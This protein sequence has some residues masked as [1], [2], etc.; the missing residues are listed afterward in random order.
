MYV[1]LTSAR[2]INEHTW[3]WSRQIDDSSLRGRRQ[4]G[5]FCGSRNGVMEWPRTRLCNSYLPVHVQ[6]SVHTLN[7]DS[8]IMEL[9][10]FPTMHPCIFY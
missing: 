8:Q 9:W 2:A 10:I 6:E 4:A 1:V 3:R 7:I 5:P